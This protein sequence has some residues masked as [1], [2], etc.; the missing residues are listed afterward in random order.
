MQISRIKYNLF[1]RVKRSW[2][3]ISNVCLPRRGDEIFTG[4]SGSTNQRSGER[5]NEEDLD[6]IQKDFT[7]AIHSVNISLIEDYVSKAC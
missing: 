3:G 6:K 7:N 2:M 5:L 1:L 4:D